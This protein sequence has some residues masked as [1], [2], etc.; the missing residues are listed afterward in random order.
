MINLGKTLENVDFKTLC[1]PGCA[2]QVC[3]NLSHSIVSLNE[4]NIYV[5]AVCP[6]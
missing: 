5:A 1:M 4:S 2:T 3:L 6:N